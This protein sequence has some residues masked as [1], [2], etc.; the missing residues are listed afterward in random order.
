MNMK[1][2]FLRPL[3]V[4]GT[5]CIASSS[6]AQKMNET[7]AA[8]AK[9][10]YASAL[11]NQDFV[12]A[13]KNLLEAKKYIDL[14]AANEETKANQKTLWLKGYIYLNIIS[15]GMMSMDT[16]FAKNAGNADEAIKSSIT[17]LK[18]AFAVK[19]KFNSD[20]E[21][22]VREQYG[23][24]DNLSVMLYKADKFK[25]AGDN[26][27]VQAS[28]FDAI[29]VFDSVAIFNSGLCYEKANDNASAAKQ[30][31]FLAKNNYKGATTYVLASACYRKNNQIAESKEIVAEGRA[32]YPQDKEILLEAVNTCLDQK[33]PV[34][35]ET[36][37]TE[38]ITKDPN[39][40]LL[41]LTIGSIYIDLKQNEKAEAAINNALAIDPN[42]EDALY[43]SGAHLVTWAGDIIAVVNEMKPND[44]KL[45]ALEKQATDIYTRALIPLE[46][47]I[48][49][50]PND[51]QVLII[52][53]QIYRQLE[54]TVKSSEYKKRAEA[55]K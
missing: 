22:T 52:L 44:P 34:G 18:T 27:A 36:L 2:F 55:V 50:S 45:K 47:Y 7:S 32:K 15:T 16:V 26:Y 33:D 24:Y 3:L 46:K 8:V 35:A 53:S 10:S 54:D 14:A 19:G 42:Y 28:L 6:L 43:Q 21:E 4:A 25:E 1:N 40:K 13:K 9:N 12:G 29:N 23:L 30:Y 48:S 17:S 37:L 51:K 39:N 5:I 49:K 11:G 41:H 31:A 20:I 38:A